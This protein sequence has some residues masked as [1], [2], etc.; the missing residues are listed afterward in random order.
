MDPL[1]IIEMSINRLEMNMQKYTD[2]LKYIWDTKIEPFINSTDCN[3]N[4]NQE[5]T[6]DNFHNFMLSQKT[7]KFMLLAYKK[8]IEQKNMLRPDSES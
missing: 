5:F 6:F 7:Y 4:F 8:L 1:K 3:I 2:D